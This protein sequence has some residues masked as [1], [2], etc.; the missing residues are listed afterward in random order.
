[1]DSPRLKA[2][3][4]GFLPPSPFF[5]P[6]FRT[7][8]VWGSLKVLQVLLCARVPYSSAALFQCGHGNR[9]AKDTSGVSQGPSPALS[10]WT[11]C[12]FLTIGF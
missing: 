10:T 9:R 8:G 5:H 6:P 4:L 2:L 12:F 3:R 1:M 11:Q 7:A